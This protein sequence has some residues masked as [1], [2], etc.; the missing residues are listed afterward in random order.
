MNSNIYIGTFEEFFEQLTDE[1]C[2]SGYFQQDG[3]QHTPQENFT[4]V[5]ESV[6]AN[7]VISSGLWPLR[8]PDLTPADFFPMVLS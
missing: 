4:A 3:A 1:E 2:Q 7:R 6:F 5:V 8:S